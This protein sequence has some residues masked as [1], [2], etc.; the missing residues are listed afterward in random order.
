MI[1][2]YVGIIYVLFTKVIWQNSEVL[3]DEDHQNKYGAFYEAYWTS[4]WIYK[5][6]YLVEAV[7][8]VLFVIFLV[9][10]ADHRYTQIYA[11]II[12]Q[13]VFLLICAIVRP[14][15]STGQ[16][17][18]KIAMEIILLF[19]FILI[20]ILDSDLEQ[21]EDERAITQWVLF[22]LIASLVLSFALYV[23]ICGIFDL[24]LTIFNALK[25]C[26]KKGDYRVA[27]VEDQDSGQS[28]RSLVDSIQAI[29]VSETDDSPIK[30]LNEQESQNGQE[31]LV[32]EQCSHGR[33]FEA[34]DKVSE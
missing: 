21:S 23:L 34:T 31:S 33:L 11:C 19:A 7:R 16:N 6:F 4:H 20:A 26:C 22:G 12:L 30:I 32:N 1:A 14:L 24:V 27:A 9:F 10:F 2:V 13:F 15:N 18:S 17:L 28:N 5:S 25:K 29:K 8:R 3:E